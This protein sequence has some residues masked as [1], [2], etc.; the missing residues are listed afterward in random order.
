MLKKITL[1]SGKT[2]EGK[3]IQETATFIKI[4]FSRV[5]LTCYKDEIANIQRGS[6]TQAE[7]NIQ[8]NQKQI[9]SQGWL[10]WHNKAKPHLDKVT[11]RLESIGSAASNPIHVKSNPNKV[12]N[13]INSDINKLNSSN[14]PQELASFYNDIKNSFEHTKKQ[15]LALTK[16]K[17]QQAINHAVQ[18]LQYSKKALLKLKKIFIKHSAPKEKIDEI[19]FLIDANNKGL[20]ML[21][22]AK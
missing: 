6:N 21:G 9:K 7:S 14:P 19:D 2:I 18:S 20:A 22:Y 15:I 4:N 8:S 12:L 16:N 11:A 17:N 1:K 10:E 13:T 5:P 3:V